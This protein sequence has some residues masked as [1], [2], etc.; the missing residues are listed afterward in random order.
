LLPREYEHYR[1]FESFYKQLSIAIVHK[2]SPGGMWRTIMEDATSY[3]ETSA[4]AMFLFGL[5]RGKKLASF[6]EMVEASI[7]RAVGALE[8]KVD[9]EGRVVDV[10]GGTLPNKASVYKALPTGEYT[11]G[12]GAWL[13]A[14]C[15]SIK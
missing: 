15:E 8:K 4:T 1:K 12:T 11:W 10:S 6:Q 3:E 13:L 5:Q 9:K 7:G 14:A 2:Q